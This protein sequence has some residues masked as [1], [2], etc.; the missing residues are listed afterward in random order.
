M[1]I[2]CAPK[3]VTVPS[4]QDIRFQLFNERELPSQGEVAA[5]MLKVI[6][7]LGLAP[8]QRAWDFLS[9][10]LAV[11]AAD[12]TY[13]RATSADGWTRNIELTVAV[14]NPKQWVKHMPLLEH[15]LGFLSTDRWT[16]KLIDG[17]IYPKPKNPIELPEDCVCL[18]S[19]GVDSL[20]GA[21]DLK[22]AGRSPLLVSQIAKG[23][24]AKQRELAQLLGAIISTCSSITM[25]PRQRGTPSVPN[26]RG[27]SSSSLTAYWRR[28]VSTNTKRARS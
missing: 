13:P 18:L 11:I 12:E 23:D 15:A 1:K 28:P 17:G 19:G 25:Q 21:L 4:G 7:R 9:I 22:A 27:L 24:K 6:S 16:I 5:S 8:N 14:S 3:S 26:G 20:V 2:A 10:A